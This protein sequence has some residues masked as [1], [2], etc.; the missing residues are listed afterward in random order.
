[1]GEETRGGEHGGINVKEASKISAGLGRR[2]N[3]I[4]S[5][6]RP[7]ANVKAAKNGSV[8]YRS[9]LHVSSYLENE[10]EIYLSNLM[11]L[12]KKMCQY[13]LLISKSPESKSIEQVCLCR[14]RCRPAARV[15]KLYL[16]SKLIFEALAIGGIDNEINSK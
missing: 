14:N 7:A 8:S 6:K 16:I 10:S 12:I 2:K 5:I 9:A 13:H 1:M 15:L 11:T 4:A 3:V